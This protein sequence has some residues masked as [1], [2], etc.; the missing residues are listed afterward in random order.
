MHTLM[1]KQSISG[2]VLVTYIYLC[3]FENYYAQN[4]EPL[5]IPAHTAVWV[6]LRNVYY[7]CGMVYGWSP[8]RTNTIYEDL[9]TNRVFTKCKIGPALDIP[10]SMP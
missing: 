4:N 9:T 5:C 1:T 10:Q 3:T 7:V 2:R 6:W 8:D